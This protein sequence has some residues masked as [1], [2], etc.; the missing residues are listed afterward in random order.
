MSK[1]MKKEEKVKDIFAKQKKHK[2]SIYDD[3]KISSLKKKYMKILKFLTSKNIDSSDI[4]YKKK[5]YGKN[6]A[7]LHPHFTCYH[8][9][10]VKAQENILLLVLYDDQK[11]DIE[12]FRDI[13]RE[14][15]F[16]LDNLFFIMIFDINLNATLFFRKEEDEKTYLLMVEE[17]HIAKF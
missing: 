7:I 11:K 16:H 15:F 5:I 10:Y 9:N 2:N 6:G 8:K 12:K 17:K 4:E 14:Y 3:I 13:C 1:K